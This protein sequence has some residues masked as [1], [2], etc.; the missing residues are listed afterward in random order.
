[1]FLG[2]CLLIHIYLDTYQKDTIVADYEAKVLYVCNFS[3]Q[4]Y[5]I[6]RRS[7]GV[8]INGL[9]PSSSRWCRIQSGFGN[10]LSIGANKK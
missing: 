9:K 8:R 7:D 1:M 4:S 2:N 5:F 3:I 10:I 6:S